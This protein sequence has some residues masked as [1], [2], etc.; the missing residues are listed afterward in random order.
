[1]VTVKGGDKMQAALAE[2]AKKLTKAANLKVGFQDGATYPGT[3]T[4][5][6]MVALTQEYGSP[7]RG[8]P[9]RSFFRTAIAKHSDEWADVLA[10]A[11]QNT[12]NDIDKALGQLGRV[13]VGQ[14]QE[15]IFD[16]SAP[17]L[18]P[19]TV[20]LRGMRTQARYKD[21]PFGQLIKEAQARV[22]AGQTSYGASS[23]PLVDTGVMVNAV[24]EVVE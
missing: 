8:I 16:L 19:V 13:I 7:G 6:A 23:K 17:A 4:S 14:I 15:S 3:G 2:I 12:D 21:L 24:T 18:S 1:M 22:A 11:L 10:A 5:V 20:M 9:P